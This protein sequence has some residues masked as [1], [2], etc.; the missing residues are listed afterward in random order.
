MEM[1]YVVIAT[2]LRRT[3]LFL[4]RALPSVYGQRGVDSSRIELVV[5]DDNHPGEN[6]FSAEYRKLESGIKS[7]REQLGLDDCR[8]R[9]HLIK[10]SKTRGNSGSGAWN[11]ALEFIVERSGTGSY[12]AILDDDDEYLPGYLMSCLEATKENQE[13]KIGAVFCRLYWDT[14]GVREIKELT[15]GSLTKENFFIGN[16]GVQGSN[17][18]FATK[19]LYLIGGFDENLPNTT[20]R[21]LMIRVFEAQESK[22]EAFELRVIEKPLVVHY[23]HQGPK[24]NN[25]KKLKQVGLDLFY[26]KHRHKFADELYKKSIKRAV[27]YFDYRPE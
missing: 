11:T 27:K 26:R 14:E 12:L 15:A 18:F 5:I 4:R 25:N 19:L 17:M 22:R 1:T 24:V 13:N 8:F 9:T 16:P 10:N 6:G 20:D 7:V 3:E 2:S 21:D 23:N